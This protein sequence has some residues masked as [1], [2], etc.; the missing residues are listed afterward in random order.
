MDKG[1]I[2]K[3]SEF[4]VSVSSLEKVTLLPPIID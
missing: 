2:A 3:S 4:A 1:K